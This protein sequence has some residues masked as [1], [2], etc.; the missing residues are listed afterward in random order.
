MRKKFALAAALV[1]MIV[2]AAP[3]RAGEPDGT[4]QRLQRLESL[5]EQL[6][7]ELAT[8]KK[9]N[10]ELEKSMRHVRSQA[11]KSSSRQT[12]NQAFRAAMANRMDAYFQNAVTGDVFNAEE[13]HRGASVDVG[14]Y[15][16]QEFHS[17]GRGSNNSNFDQHRFIV[18]ISAWLN[19]RLSFNSEIEFEGGDAQS[20][21]KTI[22]PTM[23]N[24]F[25]NR[26]GG[27]QVAVEQ[28]YLDW[29]L[30]QALVFR[31]GAILVP[32]GRLN[33]LHDSDIR[34]FTERPL[35][36]RLIV[37]STWT[38]AGA[39]F[40]GVVTR[41]AVPQLP[42]GTSLNYEVYVVN[43][44]RGGDGRVDSEAED[45]AELSA[46]IADKG[47]RDARA[48]FRDDNNSNKAIVGRVGVDYSPVDLDN[49]IAHV[50]SGTQ[51]GFSYYHG[52]LDDAESVKLS[53]VG[54]DV[55]TTFGD[56]FEECLGLGPGP[57]GT[58]RVE[59]WAEGYQA[60]ID[61]GNDGPGGIPGGLYGYYAELH[62]RFMPDFFKEILPPDMQDTAAL[63]LLG[64]YN[65]VD[66]DTDI[67]SSG[68]QERF[69][70]GLNFRP[71]PNFVIKTEYQ[72]NNSTSGKDFD[73]NQFVAS[74]A[75][76]F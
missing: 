75:L 42:D 47:F 73:D 46:T 4:E 21:T 58:A 30:D 51:V 23:G 74:A 37:P 9:K 15:I 28:A 24:S 56:F 3:A 69:E 43:G 55:R 27:G 68:D 33:L 57:N 17:N 7:E 14:G 25:N 19:N 54:V 62:Y 32:F 45:R 18:N 34:E 53:M 13:N 1:C 61:G 64:R 22:T 2:S 72:M 70:F 52:A 40:H 71:Y 76:S 5:Y 49:C 48:G 8:E 44:L 63:M 66:L 65:M 38:E 6:A 26:G 60:F 36:A 16:D 11:A 31:A 67:S 20:G 29:A 39:G 35:P 50:A 59:L 10:Y 41:D 12:D